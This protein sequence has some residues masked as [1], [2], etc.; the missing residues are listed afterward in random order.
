M[1]SNTVYISEK[2]DAAKKATEYV[3]ERLFIFTIFGGFFG[4][5]H[6]RW[7]SMFTY[8]VFTLYYISVIS[9]I[10]TMSYSSFL[11]QSNTSVMSGC[12]HMTITGLVVSCASITLQLARK[13]LFKLLVNFVLDENLCEYQSNEYFSHLLKK[14]DEKLRSLLILWLLLYGSAASIAVVFPFVDVYLGYELT[15]NNVTNVYW[16]GLPF[17]LWWPMDA[18][19]STFAWMTCFTSQGLYAMFAASLCTGCMVFYAMMCENIF[20]HIKLL[21]FSLEHLDERATL[22]F[23]KLYPGKSP[24]KMRDLYDEC[25][26]ACIVQNVKH[27]HRIVIFKDAVMKAANLPIAMPF[28]GGAL[29]LGL[30]GINLLSHDDNRIAPKVFF[31]CLGMTEAGQMFLLCK[32]GERYQDLSE[33]LFNASFYTSCFRRSMKCRRAMMIF[34]LGVS[35]PMRMTAAKIILLNME[36]FANLVNS[37]YSIFNLQSVT[38]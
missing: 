24:K 23:K 11:N 4:F 13:D 21:V 10:V 31:S 20:N 22:M 16:R 33:V 25:Y 5:H 32:Y 8:T 30:A 29:L 28:F 27:H 17:T 19:N 7:W 9:M 6:T 38:S 2:S 36:T 34:R 14:A 3:Y 15:L 35:K 26:Y 18:D 12:L 1:S 37:A